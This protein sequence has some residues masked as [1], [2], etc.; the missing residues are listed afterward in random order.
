MKSDLRNNGIGSFYTTTT[1]TAHKPHLTMTTTSKLPFARYSPSE[2]SHDEGPQPST[3]LQLECST[4]FR[5]AQL[6]S[7]EILARLDL[8]Q[9]ITEH[10][11]SQFALHMLGDCEFARKSY[12]LAKAF[13]HRC[14]VYDQNLYRWKEAQCLHAV[15]S[16]VEAAS[17][18]ETVPNEHRTMPMNMALANLYVETSRKPAAEEIYR[19]CVRQN[20]Y[21]L[22]ALEI[23]SIDFQVEKSDLLTLLQEGLEARGEG[24][25]VPD[26]LQDVM[27]AAAA[28][29]P[30]Y[31]S[32]AVEAMHSWSRFDSTYPNNTYFLKRKA[33]VQLQ[34]NHE[35][36][37]LET[38]EH[39][40]SL[41]NATLEHMDEYA[42]ILVH[43]NDLDGLNE[44]ADSMLLV[45]DT[46]P[47]PWV[48]LALYHQARGDHEKAQAFCEK[49]IDLDH[50]H[51]LAHRVQG[52]IF[53]ADNR[54][55]HAAVAFFRANELK[56]DVVCLEGL[57]DAY[58]AA[59]KGK[60]A[61]D[62]AKQVLTLSY[63]EARS[64]ALLG[65]AMAKGATIVQGRDRDLA[66]K[67]LRRAL[68]KDPTAPRPLFT[69]VD[70]CLHHED[71]DECIAILKK[72][73]EGT[74]E[75][76]TT[77]FRQP[78]PIYCRLGEVYT[79]MKLYTDALECFHNALAINPDNTTA[80]RA[81]ERTERLLGG[82]DPESDFH[83]EI[84]EDA[85]SQESDGG[86]TAI[87]YNGGAEY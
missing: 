57:V 81:L 32:K 63:E 3:P 66:K 23:L 38:F 34:C 76:L 17:V 67:Y 12:A 61:R 27:M 7:C 14:Y 84:V 62:C 29:S 28:T 69:L 77:G 72:G 75:A 85:P 43:K 56:R 25:E 5:D 60:E 80:A 6:K 54:V 87:P 9:S 79:E 70:L 71:Y 35:R 11:S 26:I 49:A 15:G 64:Q 21:A 16:F 68:L 20:P 31:R 41:E 59:H 33:T 42:E 74:S 58:L 30:L 24:P 1:T 50:R 4:L 13:Y 82:T 8:S 52:A 37:A 55:E 51:S 19:T 2:S 18:L 22:E 39:I 48:A 78:D 45:D 83:D 53:L 65:L 10:R 73:L 36:G 86:G 40:R 46:R 47:Q 44:V